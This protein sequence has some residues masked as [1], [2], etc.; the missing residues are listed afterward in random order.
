M[1]QSIN[2]VTVLTCGVLSM[3]LGALWYGP[4][5]GKRWMRLIGINSNNKK[6]QQEMQKSAG[7]LYLAQFLLVLFQIFTL[8]YFYKDINEN[9]IIQYTLW[10]WLA[11]VVPSLAGAI[12]WTNEKNVLKW[13]RFFIQTG[14]QLICF[15]LFGLIFYFWR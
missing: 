2:F 7:P 4:L 9:L 14:Y 5:F 12:M 10:I 6:S 11:F 15:T 8:A 1:Q 13:E 3:V